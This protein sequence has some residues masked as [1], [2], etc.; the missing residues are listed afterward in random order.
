MAEPI[1]PTSKATE[2]LL[3]TAA[4]I[5]A[6]LVRLMIT[7]GVTFQMASELLKRV[8]VRAAQK[9]F[10]GDDQATGTQLSLLTGLNRKEI[11]R[12]TANEAN[13]KQP[14]PMVSYASA[15]YEE[16]RTTQ[17]WLDERN[18]PKPLPLRAA[19]EQLSFD[20]LVRSVTTDHRP[21]AILEELIRL[22]FVGI[23]SED[24]V[25][26]QPHPFFL[27]AEDFEDRLLSLGESTGDHL[28][29][30]VMNAIAEKPNTFLDRYTFSDEL[31]EKS[32]ALLHARTRD[33]WQRI[34]EDTVKHAIAAEAADI[35]C[36]AKTKT[37]IKVGMYFYSENQDSEQT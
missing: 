15:V 14:V 17:L 22:G 12:L 7:R 2:K 36:G 25:I 3:N 11:R 27:A 28:N 10:V 30:A 35:E 32:A 8:Y 5:L 4:R 6:P 1:N 9:H 13:E 29:A 16:W 33:H 20:G 24:R 21:A 23:D 34:Q 18:V 19:S 37:R 26:L 31:S